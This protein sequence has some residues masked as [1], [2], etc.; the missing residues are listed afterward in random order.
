MKLVPLYN[1]AIVEIIPDETEKKTASGLFVP[2]KISPYYRGKVTAVGKG[3]F[4]N[5]QRV[6]NDVKEGQIVWFL[7]NSGMG[8]EFDNASKVTKI[9]L[10]DTDIYAVEE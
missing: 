7:K 8:I 4:Q 6:P 5:A 1:K 2:H 9:I 10:A 3:Y